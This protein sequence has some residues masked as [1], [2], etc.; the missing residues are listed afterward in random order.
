[1]PDI[2]NTQYA[3]GELEKRMQAFLDYDMQN[4]PEDFKTPEG[5]IS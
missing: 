1:M 5:I 3:E 4:S 2:A